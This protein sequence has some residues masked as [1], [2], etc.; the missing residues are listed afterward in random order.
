MITPTIHTNGTHIDD[1]L[2]QVSFTSS[3][4]S[5]A[6][7]ALTDAAPHGRDYYPQGNDA[8]PAANKVHREHIQTLVT[9]HDYYLEIEDRILGMEFEQCH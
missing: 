3:A 4:I 5:Q 1:L 8:F 2:K 6:I 9:L 7:E